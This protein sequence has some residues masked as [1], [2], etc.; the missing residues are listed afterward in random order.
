MGKTEFGGI[1]KLGNAGIIAAMSR[2]TRNTLMLAVLLAADKGLA[3][4]R[5]VIIARQFSFSRDLDAF[6]VANN[7]PDLLFALISGGA[8]ALAFIPILTDLLTKQGRGAVWDLFSR[9]ANLA[10]LGTAAIAVVVALLAGP[11]VRSQIGVAPGFSSVQ[12]DVVINLMRLNLIATLIFSISGLVTA[13]LQANQHFLLPALAPM[14]YN[15]GQIFGALVLSPSK[16]YMLAGI[17]LPAMGLGVNGLVYGVIIGALLH[18]GI[19]IPG[20]IKFKFRWIPKI[21][22]WNPEVRRVLRVMVPRL[23]VMFCIQLMFVIRDN[24]ASRLAEGSVSALTYGWMIQQVPETILGSALGIALLPTISELVALEERQKFRETIE[25]CVR[26]LV[27]LTLPVAVILGLGLE[28]LIKLVFGLDAAQ[29][30]LMMWVSRGFLLGLMGHTVL[31][32]ATR[33]FYSQ[34]DALTPLKT[35]LMTLAIYIGMG[36]FMYR[37]LGAPGIALTDTTAYTTQAVVLLI[38]FG[39]REKSPVR[40]GDTLPR[41][42]IAAIAGGLVVTGITLLAGD[43]IPAV[44]VSIVS[45]AAGGIVFLPFMWKEVRSLVRL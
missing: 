42:I 4:L 27:G 17:Q 20:L 40:L 43:R 16:P 11:M 14:L 5:Q 35:A 34:Q 30:D 41:V 44:L 45:M 1:G 36:I 15:V 19:Q 22:I 29:A 2:L 18:L 24:L 7:I 12:Q 26:I 33:S 28:P 21:G 9:I 31:E 25:K 8:L 39:R 3:I 23:G 37:W 32:I 13:G 6:N 10:F 38:I